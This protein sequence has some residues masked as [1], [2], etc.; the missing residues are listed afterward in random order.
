MRHKLVFLLMCGS[1]SNAATIQSGTFVTTNGD[2]S[3]SGWL[4]NVTGPGLQ[5]FAARTTQT[6][7]IAVPLCTGTCSYNFSGT[8]VPEFVTSFVLNGVVYEPNRQ[9]YWVL[10]SM[11]FTGTPQT[12]TAVCTI[13]PTDRPG[14]KQWETKWASNPFTMTGV[15]RVTQYSFSNVILTENISGYGFTTAFSQVSE[16]R[17]PWNYSTTSFTFIPEPTTFVL[18]GAGGLLV[19]LLKRC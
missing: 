1:L 13:C 9:G 17:G 2:R 6:P 16:D 7:S 14:P 19:L 10:L 8:A 12:A 5:L 3:Y 18:A 11:S 4:L 15:I